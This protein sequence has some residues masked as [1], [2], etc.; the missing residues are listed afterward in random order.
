M[1]T[2][3]HTNKY[4][5]ADIERYHK[6]QLSP[7]EMHRLEKAALDDPFLAD[8]LEGYTTPG[9]NISADMAELHRRLAERTSETKVIPITPVVKRKLPY[10]RIAAMIVVLA[11]AA[12]LITQVT[13]NKKNDEIVSADPVKE[14]NQPSIDSGKQVSAEKIADPTSGGIG[15]ITKE[16]NK[17][18]QAAQVTVGPASPKGRKLSPVEQGKT[19]DRDIINTET[20]AV[21]EE[22]KVIG[23]QDNVVSEKDKTK[24][25]NTGV[26]ARTFDDVAKARQ[27]T[28]GGKDLSMK[29]ATNNA[30]RNQ[31]MLTFRGRVTDRSNYGVP[32]ANVTNI[33]DNAGTYTDASGYFNFRSPDTALKVQV[34]SIGF[35]N[36]ITELRNSVPT[37]QVVL[38][39]DRSGNE[40]VISN[41]RP[42]TEARANR[43][44][45]TFEEPEPA[46][47]WSN[48]DAYLANNLVPPDDYETKRVAN[49]FVEVSFEV[50]IHGEPVNF[51]VERSLCNKCDQEAI[52]LVR[53]GPKWKRNANKSGRT[54]VTIN[55]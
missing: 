25:V 41:Q 51:R 38:N 39:E 40:I 46:D 53:E 7:E 48:Y 47:G 43:N 22:L 16:D 31:A 8:A 13:L 15:S 12:Y 55:F 34:R 14:K 6:G 23:R 10:L 45:R 19:A 27:E 33:E 30:S 28:S 17:D 20:A 3:N 9:V 49:A 2:D 11:G 26:P 35:E 42:N 5:A 54:T 24:E 18:K 50:D 32:F 37:N 21:P 36:K 44:N 29:K 4:A 52:R 1:A